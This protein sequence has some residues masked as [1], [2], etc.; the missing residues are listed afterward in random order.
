VLEFID[1]AK[2][3]QEVLLVGNDVSP[4]VTPKALA[5]L[6]EKGMLACPPIVVE[7]HG[8]IYVPGANQT[9]GS[10][11]HHLIGGFGPMELDA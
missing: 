11:K 5:R 6:H 4:L 2:G 1:P 3:L 7:G 8:T 9:A 10:L